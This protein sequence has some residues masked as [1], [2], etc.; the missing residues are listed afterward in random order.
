MSRYLVHITPALATHNKELS[1]NFGDSIIHFYISAILTEVFPFHEIIEI[2][3]HDYLSHKEIALIKNADYTI[4]GGSNL[5]SSDIRH[6]N[7]WK[8][9]YKTINFLFPSIN[10]I[11]LLGVGWW[12]Y[13]GTPTWFTQHF[14]KKVFSK[15]MLHS[16]RDN[17]TQSILNSIKIK[18]VLNTSCPTTWSL[19]GVRLYDKCGQQTKCLFALTDYNKNEDYD[20]Q[21]IEILLKLY[22]RLFFFPQGLKDQEYLNSLKEYRNNK[23]KITVLI[24]TYESINLTIVNKDV[25]YVGTRLH[26]GIYCLNHGINSLIINIDNRAKEIQKDINLPCIDR[27]RQNL[28]YDWFNKK[29]ILEPISL[30]TE[31]ILKWKSQFCVGS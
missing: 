24:R 5:L 2:A 20:N 4:I 13:Q 19:D 31:S 17:Y 21:L 7:Q 9:Y 14:Y 23:D 3:S 30:P 11:L 26:L 25:D 12:Q 1:T 16:V 10:N 6:Y 27:N 28:I 18:N 15:K 29:L 8:T 22:D